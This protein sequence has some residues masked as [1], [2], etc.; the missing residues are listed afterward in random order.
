VA[1]RYRGFAATGISP[2]GALDHVE[3]AVRG[4]GGYECSRVDDEVT[5]KRGGEPFAYSLRVSASRADVG[6]IVEIAGR[7]SPE[8]IAAVR[9]AIAGTPPWTAAL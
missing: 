3:A 5:I 2:V 1:A 9:T 7:A 8:L 6:T 4:L